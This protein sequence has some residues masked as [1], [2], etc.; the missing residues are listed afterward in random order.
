MQLPGNPKK[1]AVELG[2]LLVWFNAV[3]TLLDGIH[4]LC[5]DSISTVSGC[6]MKLLQIRLISGG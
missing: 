5:R 3:I 1:E 6:R 4:C 2:A